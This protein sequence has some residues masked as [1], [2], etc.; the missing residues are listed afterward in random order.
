MMS[1]ILYNNMSD[2]RTI[3]KEI[4]NETC[5]NGSL[6]D[7][8]SILEPV[9][10]I[11]SQNFPRYN[12]AYIPDFQRYYFIKE[13]TTMENNVFKINLEVDPLMS[14]KGD[15]LALQVVVDKQSN[16][17]IG[18][19]YIDDGSLVAEVNTFTTVYNLPNGFNE[20]GEYILITAG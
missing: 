1:L 19:E 14:F 11:T 17:S 13:I 20:H 15:I 16:N 8:C 10:T 7:A 9:F 18:D 5:F 12:Y 4:I 6:R 3:R 2:N